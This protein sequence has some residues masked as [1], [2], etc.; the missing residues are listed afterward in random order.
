M[1]GTL[2]DSVPDLALSVNLT[3]EKLN[4]QTFPIDIIKTWVGNGAKILIARALSGDIN[5]DK[6]LTQD[7]ILSTLDI[8]LDIYRQNLTTT[9][10]IYPDVKEILE[11][12]EDRYI[13]AVATNKPEEFVKPILKGMGI[14]EYFDCVVG[15]NDTLEKKPS[16]KPLE[17][18]CNRYDVDVTDAV[19]VGDSKNDILAANRANIDSI[20]VSYGYNHNEDISLYNPTIIIDNF[21]ELLQIL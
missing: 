17:Y 12:L 8:F 11:V 18:I 14:F 4:K 20:A 13:L 6:N 7:E 5:I 3:L 19:M 1:D 9:T 21:K 15:A 2:I 16:P 10:T